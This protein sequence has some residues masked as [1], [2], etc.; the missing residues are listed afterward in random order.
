M[1]DTHFWVEGEAA[2]PEK[3]RLREL[4]RV[5]LSSRKDMLDKKVRLT[6]LKG[7]HGEDLLYALAYLVGHPTL[8]G[9]KSK[10]TSARIELRHLREDRGDRHPEVGPRCRHSPVI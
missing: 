4:E 5:R 1:F 2:M 3:I 8:A 10:L 6:K 7:L 9:L